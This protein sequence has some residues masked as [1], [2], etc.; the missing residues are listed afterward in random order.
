ML[1]ECCVKA[2]ERCA[3]ARLGGLPYWRRTGLLHAAQR[4]LKGAG[5]KTTGSEIVPLR[6]TQKPLRRT[7]A[8]SLKKFDAIAS[9]SHL[10]TFKCHSIQLQANT[11]KKTTGFSVTPRDEA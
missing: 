9:V 5:Y 7:S 11:P 1:S 6:A 2:E 10:R 3:A 4:K 8:T